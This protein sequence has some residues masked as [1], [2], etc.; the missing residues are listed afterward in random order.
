M[1][2]KIINIKMLKSDLDKFILLKQSNQEII[3]KI[4]T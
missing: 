4:G 1:S 3:D 2:A